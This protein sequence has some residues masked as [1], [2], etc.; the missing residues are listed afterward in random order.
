MHVAQLH[1]GLTT[2]YSV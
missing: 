2:R 1:R